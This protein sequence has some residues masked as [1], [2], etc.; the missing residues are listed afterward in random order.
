MNLEQ[1]PTRD[2]LVELLAAQDDAAGHHVIWADSSGEVQITRLPI[3]RT[4]IGFE[5]SEPTMKLR[6]PTLSQGNGYVGPGAAQDSGWV[7]NVFDALVTTWP[8]AKKASEVWYV[9]AV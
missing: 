7:D 2:Q 3:G 4:P 1:A 6:L 9:D 5:E 8:K